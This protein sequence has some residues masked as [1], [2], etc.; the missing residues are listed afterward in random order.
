MMS[1]TLSSMGV[2]DRYL[3]PRHGS[4]VVSEP[5]MT[6]RCVHSGPPTGPVPGIHAYTWQGTLHISVSYPEAVA[7]TY[8]EQVQALLDEPEAQ[9]SF[10]VWANTFVETLERIAGVVPRE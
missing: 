9:G 5:F 7:G 6:I 1:P 2:I 4:V 10:L 3:A 8:E